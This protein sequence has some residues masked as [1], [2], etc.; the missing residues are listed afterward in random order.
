MKAAVFVW[1]SSNHTSVMAAPIRHLDNRLALPLLKF[2]GYTE[3]WS[4][5]YVWKKYELS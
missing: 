4:V 1:W 5:T 3:N 2:K